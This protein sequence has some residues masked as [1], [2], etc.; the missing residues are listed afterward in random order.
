MVPVGREGF[1]VEGRR[2]ARTTQQILIIGAAGNLGRRLARHLLVAGH[3]LRLMEHRS[4]VDQELA[5]AEAVS[6]VQ[7]DLT[8]PETL[9]AAF[10]GVD[11]VV[12]LAGVLF[13]PR[14]ERFLPTTNVTFVENGVR[15]A[16]AAGVGRFILVS[17]PHVEGESDPENPAQG[18]LEGSPGSVHARTRL[19]AE[20]HLFQECEA[21]A[22]SP[23]VL[24]SGLIYARGILLIEAAR[25]LMARRL[26]GVWREPTWMHLLS[27]PDFLSAVAAAVEQP[28]VAGVYNLGDEAPLTL[29]A[30]L[31]ALAEHWGY[32]RPW[33]APLG[34]FLAAAWLTEA[35]AQSFGTTAPL[36]RDFIRI[37]TASYVMDT[38]RARRELVPRLEHPRLADGWELLD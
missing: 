25:W 11:C 12:H 8:A 23:I 7:A 32:P 35:F 26:L 19:Q 9:E 38:A 2:M 15:A 6:V 24:R 13:A 28:D 17:F 10:N 16:L 34:L 33:R 30:F 27:L 14:P 36:T 18:G 3:E 21:A 4:P 37:G 22:M 31:D 5:A 20:K 1:V 29:Q